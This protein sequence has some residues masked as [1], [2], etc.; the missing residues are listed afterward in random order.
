MDKYLETLDRIYVPCE[1]IWKDFTTAS[2]NHASR[3]RWGTRRWAGSK[4]HH[5]SLEGGE[6]L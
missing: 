6:R 3:P 4:L 1:T 2:E 5:Q